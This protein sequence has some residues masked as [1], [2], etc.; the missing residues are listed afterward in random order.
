M[1]Y[2]QD[3]RDRLLIYQRDYQR[4]NRESRR[5][6]LVRSRYNITKEQYYEL[7]NLQNGGCAICETMNPGRAY[8]SIDH[9]HLCC[10]GKT[11]CGLCIRGLLCL[12]CN[13]A[14]GSFN[15]DISRLNRAITYIE[16]GAKTRANTVTIKPEDV[17]KKIEATIQ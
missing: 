6:D 9:D 4:Q 7:L 12:A 15:D 3:N 1:T 17:F 13:T 5:W 8:F 10:A 2:Y 14:I 11:S 16:K